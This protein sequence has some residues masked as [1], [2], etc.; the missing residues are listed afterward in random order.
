ME[1]VKKWIHDQPPL[2][3]IDEDVMNIPIHSMTVDLMKRF[4]FRDGP[5]QLFTTESPGQPHVSHMMRHCHDRVK[6]FDKYKIIYVV[7]KKYTEYS[8]RQ[9]LEDARAGILSVTSDILY[10]L[11]QLLPDNDTVLMNTAFKAVQSLEGDTIKSWDELAAAT[12]VV[13]DK[14][15][16]HYQTNYHCL[17]ILLD[18]PDKV[19]PSSETRENIMKILGIFWSSDTNWVKIWTH[20][21]PLGLTKHRSVELPEPPSILNSPSLKGKTSLQRADSG[22]YIEAST[23]GKGLAAVDLGPLKADITVLSKLRGMTTFG[24]ITFA[25]PDGPYVDELQDWMDRACIDW[26]EGCEAGSRLSQMLRRGKRLL[27]LSG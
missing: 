23:E 26:P 7:C 11:G 6:K 18:G 16:A 13:V 25:P 4:F 24:R 10:Q 9:D 2:P 27:G 14:L 17:V 19:T 3:E 22:V 1:G 21:N 12:T 15:R 5:A 8:R 20:C